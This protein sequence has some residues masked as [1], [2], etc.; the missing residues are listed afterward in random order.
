[1]KT[2]VSRLPNAVKFTHK[3]W[4]GTEYQDINGQMVK[5]ADIYEINREESSMFASTSVVYDTVEKA[6]KGARDYKKDVSKYVQFLTGEN[7]A[8]WSLVVLQNQTQAQGDDY[9]D[10]YK[11][12]YIAT[13]D[14]WK[15]N[16]QL[17]CSWTRQG[18]DFSVYTNVTMPWQIKYD[19]NVAC[20]C[21]P[22]NYNPVGLYR[23]IF[24]VTNDMRSAAG[25][26]YI[27]F[28][29]VESAYY[30]YVNG[31]EVGYS[32]DSY[33]PHSFDITDYLN[34]PDAENL[35]AVKVHKFCDGTWM[36]DQD[37]FY[38]GGIFRDVYLYSAPLVHIQDYKVE[39]DLDADYRNAE[40]KLEITVANASTEEASGCKADVKLYDAEGNVFA[41][42]IVLN[43]GMI[44]AAGDTDGKASA[45]VTTTIISPKLWSAETPYLYTMVLSL[46]DSGTSEYLGSVSQQLGFR[47]IEFTRTEV[48]EDG[49][50]TTQL[51]DYEPMRI[52]GKQLLLKGV[53]RHDT[54]PVYGKYV[55]HEIQEEDVIL[56]KQYNINAIRTSHYSNDEYLYYLCDKYGLYMMAETNLESHALMNKEDAQKN[57]KNLAM[58]R[59]ITAFNRLKNRTAVIMWSIGNENY[60]TENAKKYADGMFFDLIWYF[61]NHDST[62]PVHC[63]SSGA[64]SGVDMVSNMYAGLGTVS[65][66]SKRNMPFMLCEY[67]HAMGNA[68]GNLKEYWDVFRSSDNM[69][70]GFIWDWVDQARLLNLDTLPE[71]Y[72]FT[73]RKGVTGKAVVS[74]W[75]AAEKG[76]LSSKSADAYALFNCD[77]YNTSF[78]GSD[79]TF[80]FEVICKP[81]STNEMVLMAKGD[82]QVALKT[83]GSKRLEFFVFNDGSWH[84]VAAKLP[85]NWVGNWHQAA[86]SYDKGYVVLYCDG[87]QLAAGETSSTIETSDFALGLGRETQR[88]GSFIGEISL[89][90]IY[91]KALSVDELRAQYSANP[92][93]KA[94]DDCVIL[95]A[96]LAD[97][98]PSDYKKPYDYYA[99]DYAH[100][101]L[102]AEESK[103]AY[104]GYGGDSGDLPNSSSFCV[105]GLLSP[106]RDVQPELYEVRYQYQSVWFKATHAQLNDGLVETYNENNFLNLND[107]DVMWTLTEDAV[108][109]GSGTLTDTNIAGR[110]TR[111][112]E[113][114]YREYLPAE[115]K[116]GAEYY[117]KLSVKLKENTL[118]AKAGHEVAYEQF[119]LPIDVEQE[120][121][122]VDINVTVDD[123]TEN[124]IIVSG[125]NFSFKIDKRTGTIHNYVY[126]DN[127][128]LEKGPVPNYWR[129]LLNNDSGNYDRRWQNVNKGVTASEIT[130]GVN[131][132]G[133]TVITVKLTS[134]GCSA[135]KQ[136]MVYTVDGSGAVSV[137]MVVDATGTDL[138]R[139][140]R[141]GTVMELPAGYENVEWYGNGPVE[142]MW[143]RE[144]FAVVDRYQSTVSEMFYPYLDTQDTGTVTGVKWIT[145]TK[146]DADSAMAI[147]ARDTVE[148]S[149]LHFTV[150]DLHQARHPYELTELDSTI[151]T[152]NYR[153]QGTGNKSCGTDTL[154]S[155]QLPNDKVYSYGYTM[156]PYEMGLNVMD[157]TRAYRRVKYESE[158]CIS[159]MSDQTK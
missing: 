120:T 43:L 77:S 11:T 87:E 58:D 17:P 61:K 157:V 112:L 23:K 91:N 137:K 2:K 116:A 75:T 101:R 41:D 108:V 153:S 76:A 98:K 34:E 12:D 18:F 150:D 109:I 115:K 15:S 25:R 57:F 37:M 24:R 89:G 82:K 38:D 30:V 148:A 124:V 78:G 62:R 111:C 95:W 50:R 96:D 21:A 19:S 8:D 52:N 93:I 110:E 49:T 149:A 113:V 104:F 129:G 33:S 123:A 32:E 35:L 159:D 155:Y 128:L 134:A 94:D 130:T 72:V 142:A 139:F 146:P 156:I 46:Y 39:T 65:A 92:A 126:G 80:T 67:D 117:L 1:M 66:W 70:G 125:T 10:F 147:A 85:D 107:F 79:K 9:K 27:S 54:D 154:E 20:P 64:S 88:G 69:L 141:I 100:K 59:T 71:H 106:D 99:Q 73:E 145:V 7:A 105:N 60:Y 83:D 136:T 131:D 103:G 127:V 90:R 4:T 44:P 45:T 140:I 119:R 81:R 158:K 42:G 22:V 13:T 40:L 3:E 152:V 151:L 135:L 26:I 68:V 86:A 6:I 28:Q 74:A 122:T 63:E 97:L 84:T 48:D 132:D 143:D 56:M 133:Q 29:G 138:G 114:P 31:K 47:E 55:S 121:K 53:N 118:W 16:L 36:E 102:Y 5:A 51:S 144:D 14:D